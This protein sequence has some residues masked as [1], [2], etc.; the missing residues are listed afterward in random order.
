MRKIKIYNDTKLL[1][2]NFRTFLSLRFCISWSEKW[3]MSTRSRKICFWESTERPALRLKTLPYVSRLSRQCGILNT[4]QPYRPPRPVTETVLFFLLKFNV[5][6]MV[7]VE[8][9]ASGLQWRVVWQSESKISKRL[10][11]SI[12]AV[13]LMEAAY[14]SET[15]V[16]I[17]WIPWRHSPENLQWIY[18][19]LCPMRCNDCQFYSK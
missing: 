6:M 14:P 5:L 19:H 13:H 18:I 11:A 2:L 4:S 12:L 9:I 10:E 15:L 16:S 7:N 8:I 3:K 1:K 17:W